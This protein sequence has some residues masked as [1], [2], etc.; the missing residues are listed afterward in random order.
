MPNDRTRTDL[1]GRRLFQ[2]STYSYIASMPAGSNAAHF[3]GLIDLGGYGRKRFTITNLGT[4][5]LIAGKIQS[6]PDGTSYWEV[7][8]S[9]FNGLPAGSRYSFSA[10][11]DDQYF[12][13]AGS[14][15]AANVF[16]L[17]I[18]ASADLGTWMG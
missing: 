18:R 4:S 2:Y 6:S 12:R 7:Y 13:F 17:H 1:H 9:V 5:A 14:V 16:A 8:N 15:T 10:M 3:T 11:D